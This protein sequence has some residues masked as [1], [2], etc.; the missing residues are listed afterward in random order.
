MAAVE[1]Y[2]RAEQRLG[3]I[4]NRV[5]PKIVYVLLFGA[6][7]HRVFI[8]HFLGHP[9]E[10]SAEVFVKQVV[11]ATMNGLGT[12]ERRTTEIRSRRSEPSGKSVSE[13]NFGLVSNLG[14]ISI[15]SDR[16]SAWSGDGA[17]YRKVPGEQGGHLPGDASVAHGRSTNL[18]RV[19]RNCLTVTIS[20]S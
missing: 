10:P 6:C 11:A 17:K 2:I 15:G 5:N 14:H 20:H 8:S 7:L 12:D 16:H 1:T 18:P 3:R 19:W 13:P 4:G 9:I